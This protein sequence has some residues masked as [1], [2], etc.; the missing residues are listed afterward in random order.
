MRHRLQAFL[1]AILLACAAAWSA[2]APPEQPVTAETQ[3]PDTV[4]A[5]AKA[6]IAKLTGDNFDDREGAQHALEKLD[7]SVLP[8]LRKL[9]EDDKEKKE[10]D[11]ESCNAIGHV[12]S[13]LEERNEAA[14]LRYGSYVKLA[15]NGSTPS[16]ILKEIEKQTGIAPLSNYDG[17]DAKVDFSYSGPYWG[18]VAKLFKAAKPKDA[19]NKTRETLSFNVFMGIRANP[20]DQHLSEAYEMGHGDAGICMLRVART[21]IEQ[22]GAGTFLTFLIVPHLEGRYSNQKIS[23]TPGN[24]TL[25][26]GTKIECGKPDVPELMENYRTPHYWTLS[27]ELKKG[28]KGASKASLDGTIDLEVYEL[29]NVR[30]DLTKSE[31]FTL[32]GGTT[33]AITKSDGK[34]ELRIS[35]TGTQPHRFYQDLQTH[36]KLFTAENAKINSNAQ[37]TRSSSSG[38]SWTTN[39]TVTSPEA[40][41]FIELC[42]PIGKPKVTIP[43][44]I[45][46][47]QLP[48]T[49][50][51][52]K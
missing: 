17:V 5:A 12:I 2:E 23:I 35:G 20:S 14:V 32:P 24:V 1:P 11:A 30:E 36:I 43:F 39:V 50:S 19:E 33:L 31:S 26:N 27:A 52:E 10:L 49:E 45:E 37:V 3:T 41:A 25:D 47:I 9:L 8:W 13:K 44:K 42:V 28:L 22:E 18:A 7:L 6:Q 34:L 4:I 46:D 38:S 29:K 15:M 40:A 48:R 51:Q 16:D 21:A